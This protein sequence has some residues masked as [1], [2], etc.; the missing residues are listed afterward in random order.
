[1]WWD[2][3]IGQMRHYVDAFKVCLG[4]IEVTSL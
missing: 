2:Y 1:M 4:S 3:G